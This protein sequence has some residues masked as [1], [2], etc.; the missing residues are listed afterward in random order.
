VSASVEVRFLPGPFVAEVEPGST[1]LAAARKANAPLEAPCD[2]AGICGKCLVQLHGQA[3]DALEPGVEVHGGDGVVG[4]GRLVLACDARV[5]AAV[6]ATIPSRGDQSLTIV[7]HG[8]AVARPLSPYV[9]VRESLGASMVW[10]GGRLLAYEPGPT[11]VANLGIAVDIGTTTLVVVLVDLASGRELAVASALNPQTAFGHDVLSRIRFAAEPD[12]L[13]T[14]QRVLVKTLNELIGQVCQ[15]VGAQQSHIHEAVL[16]G[17]TCMLHIVAAVDPS[18]L[19][20]APYTPSL[21]GGDHLQATD[22]GL[23]IATH[24]LVYLPPVVSG[25]VG[26]DITAGILATDLHRTRETTLLLDIGTNGEMVLAHAGEL[27][28]T[29]TA[30]GPAFEGVNITRGM[31]AAKGAIDALSA[32]ATGGWV[33]HT[34]GDAPAIGICGSGLIDLVSRLVQRGAIGKSGRFEPT[35]SPGVGAWEDDAGR[36]VLRLSG[37]VVLTQKDVRQVQLAKAAVRAGL[38]AL[39]DS[40]KVSVSG[41]KRVL[42]AGSFGYHLRPESLAGAGLLPPLLASRVEAAG[43]TCKSGAVTLLTCDSTRHELLAVAK[44]TRSVELSNDDAFSRRFVRHM[45]FGEIEA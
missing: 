25:F 40:A 24:G 35:Q 23:A 32:S 12:G 6:T 44:R 20:R 33:V 9:T 17:N 7:D 39:L 16:G 26:A 30:A 36:R 42:V 10:A 29:S 31:R 4:E 28:A 43:N 19:G 37:D 13:A 38:E 15:R 18:P 22:L 27:W 45:A 14:M 5:R 8:V 1:L 34:I 41:V 11:P 2:G 3:L 21:T